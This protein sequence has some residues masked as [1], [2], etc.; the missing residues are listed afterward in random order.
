[1]KQK[2]RQTGLTRIC[3]SEQERDLDKKVEV[4]AKEQD[5]SLGRSC[6][7]C[8][9]YFSFLRQN[10]NLCPFCMKRHESLKNGK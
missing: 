7:G 10:E 2:P 6:E 8:D 3:E 1:M 4:K 5:N 9:K